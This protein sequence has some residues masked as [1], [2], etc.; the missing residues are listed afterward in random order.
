MVQLPEPTT[1]KQ[2]PTIAAIAKERIRRA[3]KKINID[4]VSKLDLLERNTPEDLG[5]RVFKLAP[6][7]YK[8]WQ[9]PERPMPQLS[10]AE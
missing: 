4:D 5:F 2:Y 6:S 10:T 9:P 8:G 7:N 1:N 3:I